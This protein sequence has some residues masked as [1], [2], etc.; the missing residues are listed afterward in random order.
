MATITTVSISINL[1]IEIVWQLLM[2]P[3]NLKYWLTGFI[4]CE[5]ISGKEGEAG[6]ISKLKF[7]ERGKEMEVKE[8]ALEINPCQQYSFLMEHKLFK[9]RTDIRLISFVTRTEMI[10]TVQVFPEAFFMKILLTMMKS[11]MKKRLIKELLSF[12]AFAENKSYQAI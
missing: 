3:G 7:T 1:P 12:K 9:T 4:S 6:S 8:T 5:L 2:D 10:Q 11:Q